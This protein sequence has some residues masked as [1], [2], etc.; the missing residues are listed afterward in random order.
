MDPTRPRRVLSRFSLSAGMRRRWRIWSGLAVLCVGFALVSL[1]RGSSP[2][3]SAPVPSTTQMER[4][5]TVL[6]TIESSFNAT[7]IAEG[8][9]IWFNSALRVDGLA[10]GPTSIFLNDSTISFAANGKNYSLAVPAATVVIDPAATVASTGFDA[11]NI[12]WVTIVPGRLSG[13]A[14]LS[15]LAFPVPAGGLPA[16]ACTDGRWRGTSPTR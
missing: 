10:S 9:V 14:F 5:C 2:Q 6:S 7:P 4:S 13:R 8:N 11:A 3:R 15:G 16:V 1:A 12:R